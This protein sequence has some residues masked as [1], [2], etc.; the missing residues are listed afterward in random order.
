MVHCPC[1]ITAVKEYAIVDV[2]ISESCF[3]S[4]VGGD[5]SQTLEGHQRRTCSF[6]LG[7]VVIFS[8]YEVS[9]EHGVGLHLGVPI[10]GMSVPLTTYSNV[11]ECWNRATSMVSS[12]IMM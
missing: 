1:K 9:F 3:F 8:P 2:G 5:M 6:L 10:G 7:R 12:N 4:A 11:L